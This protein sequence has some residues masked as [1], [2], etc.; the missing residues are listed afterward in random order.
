MTNK[1]DLRK[2]NLSFFLVITLALSWVNGA[3]AADGLPGSPEFGYGALLSISGKD[4]WFALSQA[5]QIQLDWISIPFDW[6]RI[7]P[8]PNAQ[9]DFSNFSALLQS[10][11]QK[12]LSILVIF[13]HPPAW[14]MTPAGPDPEQT[15]SLILQLADAHPDQLTAIELFPGANTQ[16]AWGIPAN[17]QHYL[18]IFMTVQSALA[19]RHPNTILIPSLAPLPSS[20]SQGDM[21]DLNFLRSLYEDGANFPI[22]GIRYFETTGRPLTSPEPSSSNVLRHYELI[23][24]LMLEKGYEQNRIWITGF[25]WPKQIT[26]PAAQAQWLSEAFELLR[27][28][29]YI[30]AAFFAWLNQPALEESWAG[31][32]S[33]LLPNSCFHPAYMSL[34]ILASGSVPMNSE[35]TTHCP[36]VKKLIRTKNY[37]R[38]SG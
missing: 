30:G 24:R 23:R 14:A 15:A 28:Q 35:A 7:W 32:A 16:F 25:S 37:K 9:P 2:R 21:D 4:P 19:I 11:L 20:P 3:R 26:E 12:N 27:A 22:V 38:P 36:L 6:A 10:A 1:N 31:T 17:P 34:K 29:L 8:N 18:K 33:L 13:H 5:G